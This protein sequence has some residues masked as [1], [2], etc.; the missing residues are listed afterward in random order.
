[1]N[2]LALTRGHTP[3]RELLIRIDAAFRVLDARVWV[4]SAPE[5]GLNRP[6]IQNCLLMPTTLVEG[7]ADWKPPPPSSLLHDPTR[8]AQTG[9]LLYDMTE[10]LRRWVAKHVNEV[11]GGLSGHIDE[12]RREVGTRHL[13]HGEALAHPDDPLI[14]TGP[15]AV[16]FRRVCQ[17]C[18]LD[19]HV[20]LA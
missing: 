12:H 14:L 16:P 19:E 6:G 18:F 8:Y 1:M 20:E 10:R 11:H 9:A 5:V 4:R 17:R 7:A 15:L 3:R 2:E 13:E